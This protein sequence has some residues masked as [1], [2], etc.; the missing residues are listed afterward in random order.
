MFYSHLPLLLCQSTESETNNSST[1]ASEQSSDNALTL[2]RIYQDHEFSS[3]YIGRIRWLADG[4]GYTAIENSAT[5]TVNEQG[6]SVSLGKDIVVYSP[7]TLE[8][9]V[10]ITAEQLTPKNADNPLSIHDYIWSADRNKLLIYTNSKKVWRSNS[11]GD[12]WLL[13]LKTN[14]LSQ[15]GGSKV[16][17][18][19]LMFAKFSPDASKVAYV[20]NNEL[21]V[22][23]LANNTITQLTD[24]A[25]NGV[26]NGLFDWV[27]EEEFIIRDGFRWSPDGK[28]IAYWQLDTSGSKDFIMINNTDSLYPTITKFPYPKVGETNALA[29]VGVVDLTSKNTTWAKLPNNSREM[30]IPRMNWSGQ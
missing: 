12:Y 11:R 18:S 24:S 26:I 14:A 16:A 29:K 30:Y 5:K 22:E 2:K 10:L 25:K 21:F 3:D 9:T 19:S 1:T 28:K 20:T 17:D 27:Y 23:E 7:Q 8:R 15:L 6:E 13:D 4:S